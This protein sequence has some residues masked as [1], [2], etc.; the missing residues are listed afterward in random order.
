MC[1]YMHCLSPF[2]FQV[3]FLM[4]ELS[5]E[6]ANVCMAFFRHLLKL[7]LLKLTDL[8]MEL[9]WSEYRHV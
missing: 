1:I 2:Q 3:S 6:F 9:C 5:H 4:K 8:H 7:A